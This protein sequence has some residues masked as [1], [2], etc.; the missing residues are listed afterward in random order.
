MG[1]YPLSPGRMF[2]VCHSKGREIEWKSTAKAVIL[3]YQEVAIFARIATIIT[4]VGGPSRHRRI[5]MVSGGSGLNFAVPSV[6]I[7]HAERRRTLNQGR[8]ALASDA[9]RIRSCRKPV[10]LLL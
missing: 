5:V 1:K 4:L 10:A 2:V 8:S 9:T 3:S 7:F 6:R